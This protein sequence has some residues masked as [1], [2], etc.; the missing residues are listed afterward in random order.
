[1][2]VREG[3]KRSLVAA[4][5]AMLIEP[6]EEGG[7]GGGEYAILWPPLMLP[8]ERGDICVRGYMCVSD[9][10]TQGYLVTSTVACRKTIEKDREREREKGAGIVWRHIL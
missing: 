10:L 8:G 1:M 5:I 9:L 4:A 2:T 6:R 7:R 3:H